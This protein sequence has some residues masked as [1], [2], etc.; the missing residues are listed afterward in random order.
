MNA[1]RNWSVSA[2]FVL[3]IEDSMESIFDAVKYPALIHQERRRTF[4]LL[5]VETG[6]RQSGFYSAVLPADLSLL[7]GLLIPATGCNK[8][9]PACGAEQIWPFKR[10]PSGY[11]EFINPRM[12]LT[13]IIQY[14]CWL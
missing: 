7:C 5:A 14:F 10:R 9:G 12:T 2:C 1:G 13:L 11:N 3:P 8:T 4:F 6:K